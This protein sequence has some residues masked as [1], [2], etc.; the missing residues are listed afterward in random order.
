MSHYVKLDKTDFVS[1]FGEENANAGIAGS[2]WEREPLLREW[3]GIQWYGSRNNL[4]E[5]ST[6]LGQM[7]AEMGQECY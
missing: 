5:S 7:F 4:S 2:G 3:N 6:G 1:S